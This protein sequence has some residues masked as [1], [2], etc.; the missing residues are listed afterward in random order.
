MSR[1]AA[2]TAISDGRVSINGRV[3]VLGDKVSL[4]DD[5]ALDGKTVRIGRKNPV[6]IAYHKPPGI[7]CTSDRRVPENIIDAVNY[8]ERVFHI[9]RLDKFSEGLILL[10]N[11]GDIVNKI[12]RS[13]FFHEKEYIVDVNE[14]ISDRAIE[15]LAKGIRLEDGPTRPCDVTRL[16]PKRI[17]MILTEGRNRQIRRMIQYFDLRVSKLKR[18]RVIN[19]KLGNLPSG[20]WRKLTKDEYDELL[21]LIEGKERSCASS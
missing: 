16:G 8:P 3:A 13:R 12:L 9:G 11:L 18:I 10:T 2:D 14:P 21:R 7:E 19:I 5:I 17:R 1:R 6:I 15:R 20:K 4:D